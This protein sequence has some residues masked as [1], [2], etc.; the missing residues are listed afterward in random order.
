M[1]CAVASHLAQPV[2]KIVLDNQGVVKATPVPRRGVIKDQDYLYQSYRN[3]ITKNLTVR[4]TPGHRDATQPHT[5]TM[6]T[7][8]G[9]R[10]RIP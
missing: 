2:D 7:Y 10:T 8:R 6:W 3:V 5:K 9:T 4:W 1:A